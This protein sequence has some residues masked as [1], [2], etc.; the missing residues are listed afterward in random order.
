MFQPLRRNV[1]EEES[2]AADEILWRERRT[3]KHICSAE[4]GDKDG[5]E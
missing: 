4:D 2:I 3:L 1:Q 5:G